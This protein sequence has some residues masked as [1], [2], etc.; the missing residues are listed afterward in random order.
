MRWQDAWGKSL[1]KTFDAHRLRDEKA[2][3]HIE[4]IRLAWSAARRFVEREYRGAR[5]ELK[6]SE[7]RHSPMLSLAHWIAVEADGPAALGEST[8]TAFRTYL[9]LRWYA[10]LVG[11]ASL[12]P[13]LN[14]T[15]RRNDAIGPGFRQLPTNRGFAL[16]SI[17][18]DDFATTMGASVA[19]V[20]DGVADGF[21]NAR[22]HALGDE[23][24]DP[25]FDG[26]TGL[27][28]GPGRVIDARAG[29]QRV[30]RKR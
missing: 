15:F 14:V 25:A 9:V 12:P 21:R 17:L 18:C 24:A 2:G 4:A 13:K 6:S 29:R 16:I 10:A 19:E 30:G 7:G 23:R 26:S 20:I 5:S 1:R 28:C 8:P 27:H 3:E 11:D 22:K